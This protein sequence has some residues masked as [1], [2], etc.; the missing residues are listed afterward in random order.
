MVLDPKPLLLIVI[1]V[2]VDGLPGLTLQPLWWFLPSSYSNLMQ[3]ALPA[4][5]VVPHWFLIQFL[6][7]FT[8]KCSSSSLVGSSLVSYS[9]LIK[10]WCKMLF[11]TL[12]CF[13]IGFLF[14]SNSKWIQNA[15]QAALVV[16]HWFLIQ[17][18]SKFNGKCSSSSLV[19]FSSVSYSIP[20]QNWYKMLFKQP[21]WF[22]IGFLLN[23]D[24]Q[25]MQN[26]LQAALVV[27]RRSHQGSHKSFLHQFLTR[28]E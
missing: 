18:L 13:L 27:P 24:Q 1:F 5:L 22:L 15:T 6:S 23:S 9:I 12:C 10:N 14:N 3:N 17:F 4:A 8:G 11:W 7:K 20:I 28:I 19:G 26:A 21:W 16:P 25:L 2:N